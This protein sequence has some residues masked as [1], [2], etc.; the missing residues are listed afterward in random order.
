[1]TDNGLL[2]KL[3]VVLVRPRFPE[4]IGAA[5][6]ACANMG[7]GQ[8]RLVNPERP[9]PDPM[10]RLATEAGSAYLDEMAVFDSLPA[11]LADCSAALAATARGGKRRGRL[12]TPRRAAHWALDQARQGLVAL[13]F[14]SED[15]GLDNHEV[16]ACT[17]S[18]SIPTTQKS[19]LNLAQAVVVVGY[20]M[21]MQF[22]ENDNPAETADLSLAPR[23]AP[24]GEF[25]AM[26]EHLQRA[27]SALGVIDH[28][29]PEHFMRP[30]KTSLE[31]A[32]LTSAEVRAWRGLAR[33]IL[34]L[35]GQLP[36]QLQRPQYNDKN[37]ELD[38]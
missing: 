13:V 19:S 33:Q 28:N 7:L 1:M 31:R 3:T 8:L 29:N 32:G 26:K 9:W 18:V 5:A 22:L 2:K 24:L 16:D 15:R 34:W 20:E 25:L 36:A 38:R 10:R 14:G 6:R 27:L 17:Y 37:D 21:R 4:N 30:Y 11:A 12:L 23:S 35:H